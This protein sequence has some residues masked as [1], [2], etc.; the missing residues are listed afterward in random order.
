[1][2]PLMLSETALQA[3]QQVS[4]GLGEGC[5]SSDLARV[6]DQPGLKRI[7][8]SLDDD[9]EVELAELD[10]NAL[11]SKRLGLLAL[12]LR[13]GL[14]LGADEALN[15]SQYLPQ[16]IGQAGISQHG[17]HRLFVDPFGERISKPSGRQHQE[18]GVILFNGAA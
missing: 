16:R 10:I 15:G 11:S 5:A 1:M 13:G 4:A 2:L 8:L 7:P 18:G 9:V 12:L 17:A 6:L 14:A 3:G